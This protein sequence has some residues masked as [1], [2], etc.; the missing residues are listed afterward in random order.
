V[1]WKKLVMKLGGCKGKRS[2]RLVMLRDSLCKY[3]IYL[4]LLFFFTDHRRGI[5]LGL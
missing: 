1:L 5:A 3:V 2:A 4:Y